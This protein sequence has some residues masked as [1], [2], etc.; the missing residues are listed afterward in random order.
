[1]IKSIVS[2]SGATCIPTPFSRNR[3]K[4]YRTVTLD[5][6]SD[7]LTSSLRNEMPEEFVGPE[8]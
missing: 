7:L 2:W 3:E 4:S 8:V 1:M 5:R 6:Q